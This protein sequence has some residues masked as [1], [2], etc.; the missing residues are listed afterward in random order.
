M[1]NFKPR[2]ENKTITALWTNIKAGE[3]CQPYP[4]RPGKYMIE[5]SKELDGNKMNLN[6]GYED[7]CDHTLDSTKKRDLLI[8]EV[9]A[10]FIA[11]NLVGEGKGNATVTIKSMGA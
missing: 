2:G 4:I 6:Y 7:S 10:G 5:V 8:V 9:A 3:K 11:P 1:N